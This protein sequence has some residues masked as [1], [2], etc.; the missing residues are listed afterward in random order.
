MA[1][2]P[3]TATCWA[4]G[5]YRRWRCG[6]WPIYYAALQDY[7]KSAPS[8]IDLSPVAGLAN[9]LSTTG[10]KIEYKSPDTESI[11][12]GRMAQ[13]AGITGNMAALRDKEQQRQSDLLK[14]ILSA[15][16]NKTA[17]SASDKPPNPMGSGIEDRFKEKQV[18]DLS[19]TLKPDEVAA[20]TNSL[21]NLAN[22]IGPFDKNNNTPIPGIGQY[23][24]GTLTRLI[25]GTEAKQ[26]ADKNWAAVL[27][28]ASDVLKVQSGSAVSDQE[29][30][31]FLT[32][33]GISQTSSPSVLRSFLANLRDKLVAKIGQKKAGYAKDVLEMYHASPD[34]IRETDISQ[35]G[36]SSEPKS[37]MSFEDWVKAGKPSQ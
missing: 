19:K 34:A 15:Q 24:I 8:E 12:N 31:R 21:A 32:Q 33:S 26:V 18:T 28:A 37:E 10:R 1:L 6:T 5:T 2:S 29:L 23:G 25:P 27:T 4:A 13:Y 35:I 22:L 9:F 16:G 30:Q 14:T 17:I 36:K 20:A 3:L 7:A 11:A